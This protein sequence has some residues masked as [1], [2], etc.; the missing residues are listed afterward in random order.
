MN[1]SKSLPN[2][3]AVLAILLVIFSNHQLYRLGKK[4]YWQP[5]IF[6]PAD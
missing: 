1:G 4:M 2:R 5:F 6:S 3:D